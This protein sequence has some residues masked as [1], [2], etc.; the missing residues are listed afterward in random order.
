MIIFCKQ[1]NLQ[2]EV[3]K[4]NCDLE[5]RNMFIAS[6]YNDKNLECPGCH[7]KLPFGFMISCE[8]SN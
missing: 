7:Q 5:H 1:C 2:I 8:E 4:Y 6:A 3:D